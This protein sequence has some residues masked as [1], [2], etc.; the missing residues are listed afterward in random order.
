M[1]RGEETS[2]TERFAALEALFL[3]LGSRAYPDRIEALIRGT[4][5]LPTA[6]VVAAC[7]ELG[8]SHEGRVTLALVRRRSQEILGARRRSEEQGYQETMRHYERPLTTD[9]REQCHMVTVL[10]RRHGL[11]WCSQ[12]GRFARDGKSGAQTR[13]AGLSERICTREAIHAAWREVCGEDSLEVQRRASPEP[14]EPV[15]YMAG[16]L[17]F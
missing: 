9:E 13:D 4:E 17:E 16:E 14:S 3:E 15:G 5:D 8:R 6:D 11:Y 7:R 10:A 2:R 1:R 12:E